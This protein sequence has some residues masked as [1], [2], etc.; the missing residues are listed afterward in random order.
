MVTTALYRSPYLWS[1][2]RMLAWASGPI[3]SMGAT[4]TLTSSPSTSV[5]IRS[6]QSPQRRSTSARRAE[7]RA[8]PLEAIA[9]ALIAGSLPIEYDP[10]TKSVA[11]SRLSSERTSEAIAAS[12]RGWGGKVHLGKGRVGDGYGW[13]GGAGRKGGGGGRRGECGNGVLTV[14]RHT[15]CLGRGSRAPHPL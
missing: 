6:S 5:C 1:S 8:R 7:K 10:I 3:N 15:S 13:R 4:L 9:A 11:G 14:S 2:L 12:A